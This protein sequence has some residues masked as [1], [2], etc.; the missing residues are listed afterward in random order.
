LISTTN[1][2]E[3]EVGQYKGEF[4]QGKREGQGKMIW[5]D[6]SVFEGHWKNDERY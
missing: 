3:F 5:A 1:G 4:R 6:G 2:V